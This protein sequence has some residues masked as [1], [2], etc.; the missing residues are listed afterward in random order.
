VQVTWLPFELHP[1]VPRGGMPAPAYVR[2]AATSDAGARLRQMAADSGREIVFNTEWMP[3]T[4]RALE[5]SEHARERGRH[6]AFHRAVF[7]RFYGEGKDIEQWDVLAD[8][9]REV[10][11]DASAMQQATD[12]GRYT[13]V[14][15]E[16]IHNAHAAGISGVPAYVLGN[17]YLIMGAQPYEVFQQVMTELGASPAK[18]KS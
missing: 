8:A 7:H 14:V 18:E 16:H 4:R 2:R 1:E 5:A 13:A 11:L 9:A 17:R 6:E 10:G 3:N 15:D 12:S